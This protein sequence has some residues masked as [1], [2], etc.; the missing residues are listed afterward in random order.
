MIT[1]LNGVCTIVIDLCR[2][3]GLTYDQIGTINVFMYLASIKKLYGPLPEFAVSFTA[4]TA[5]TRPPSLV[6]DDILVIDTEC[7]CLLSMNPLS[8]VVISFRGTEQ[9]TDIITDLDFHSVC[10]LKDQNL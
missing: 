3:G 1:S 10:T 8:Q 5:D 7:I 6:I 9:F 4:R 2:V